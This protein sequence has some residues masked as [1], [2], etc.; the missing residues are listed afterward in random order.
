MDIYETRRQRLLKLKDEKCSGKIVILAD[1][2]DTAQ[3][4][5][6]RM[7]YEKDKKGR[8]NISDKM[9]Q[10]I[11]TAFKLPRGWLDG[12]EQDESLQNVTHLDIQPS[13]KSEYPILG[14][15]SAGKFKEALQTFDLQYEP[16]TVKCH[17]S[18][19]WLI[20]DGHSM[21]APQGTG[22]SFL[23]GMLIL[24]DPERDYSNGNFVVAY[25]ENK[26]MATF[27]KISIEPEGIFLVPLNPDTTYKRINIAEEF[28][29]IAGVVVDAKWKL[30]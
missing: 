22:I 17:Q 6:S 19:Y 3:S 21:T 26:H 10:K 12:V 1:K 18:S 20:V 27:K 11:E 2:I 7:L 5:V 30:F 4:Y 14:K 9:V 25:C 29:E 16:T 28:C 15:V 13:Y 23:E 8:K 24:V